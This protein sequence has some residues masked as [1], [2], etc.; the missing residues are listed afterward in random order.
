MHHNPVKYEP[1]TK[2]GLRLLTQE[3]I[4]LANSLYGY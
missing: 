4:N 3:E 2:G 1:I